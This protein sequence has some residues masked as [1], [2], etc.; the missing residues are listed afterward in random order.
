M[1]VNTQQSWLLAAAYEQGDAEAL[2]AEA[3]RK[4]LTAA[5]KAGT[6]VEAQAA[7]QLALSIAETAVSGAKRLGALK[8]DNAARAAANDNVKAGVLNA[9][10]LSRA[11]SEEAELRPLLTALTAAQTSKIADQGKRVAELTGLIAAL[12]G[13]QKRARDEAATS[14][15]LGADQALD[16]RLAATRL[17]LGA[18]GDHTGGQAVLQAGA[19]ALLEAMDKGYGPEQTGAHY[20][21]SVAAALADQEAARAER[22]RSTVDGQREQVELSERELQLVGALP[23]VHD[24][25]I[26]RLKIEQQLKR[27]GNALTSADGQTILA[28]A[29]KL[30]QVNRRL[31][32]Q[33]ALWG[34]L[35]QAGDQLVDDAGQLLNPTSWSD[36]GAAGMRVLQ[37]L[38]SEFIKLSAINP[39]KNALFGESNPTLSGVSGLL[40]KFF[41][42]KDTFLDGLLSGPLK[43]YA[44][45]TDNAPGGPAMVGEEGA[46]IVNLPRGSSV[47]PAHET[48]DLIRALG[49]NDNRA[50][51]TVSL[52]SSLT[53]N[54][55]S[56]PDSQAYKQALDA[57]DA[58]MRAQVPG[59]VQDGIRRGTIKVGRG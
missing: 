8:D 24:E 26:T 21:K 36:W 51:V 2:K 42:P 4:A 9:S 35:K 13:E 30:D 56:G 6:E 31:V 48:R 18:V 7:R 19:S 57:R 52:V 27:D 12:R 20:Q 53:V 1:V 58:Q 17:K 55:S 11:M 37:D 38:I 49:A 34:E 41:S 29:L 40:G 14:D 33:Q 39:L 44:S 47:T 32:D 23:A 54:G 22:V 16:R 59:L 25:A 15:F 28:N 5:T 50:P 3:R 46:E 45:G 10:D 43:G